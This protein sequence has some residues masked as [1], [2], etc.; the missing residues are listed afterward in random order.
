MFI[1]KYYTIKIDMIVLI[2]FLLG[3]TAPNELSMLKTNSFQNSH[4]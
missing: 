1:M 2:D 3:A 4:T